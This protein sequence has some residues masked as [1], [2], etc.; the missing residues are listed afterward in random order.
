MR[1][2]DV[3][4][5][6]RTGSRAT[7]SDLP[8]TFYVYKNNKLFQVVEKVEVEFKNIE[9]YLQSN[10]WELVEEPAN[11]RT[12]TLTQLKSAW[13][14]LIVPDSDFGSNGVSAKFLAFVKALGY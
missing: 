12:V 14:S 13:D 2:E 9:N 7:L 3:L 5:D 8:N 10:G 6:L 4:G 11:S 1:F